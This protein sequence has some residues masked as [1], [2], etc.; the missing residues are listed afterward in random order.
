MNFHRRE[1]PKSRIEGRQFEHNE[2]AISRVTFISNFIKFDQ[3][4]RVLC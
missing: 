1:K 2:L 4:I 3:L